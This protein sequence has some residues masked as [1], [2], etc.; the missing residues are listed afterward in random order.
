MDPV[1]D[2]TDATE[3]RGGEGQKIAEHA[4]PVDSMSYPADA[5]T[6]RMIALSMK[7]WSRMNAEYV[8]PTRKIESQTA[9][10]FKYNSQLIEKPDRTFF[11]RKDTF[12]EYIEAAARMGPAWLS[13]GKASTESKP[14][15]RATAP[16]PASP[17][18]GSRAKK[19]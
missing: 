5:E 8:V 14:G 12:S 7:L 3:R 4:H 10:D 6:K 15:A 17:A 11:H 18:S 16:L 9:A 13:N 19:P 1:S 2:G